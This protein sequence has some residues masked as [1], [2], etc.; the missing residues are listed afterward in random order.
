MIERAIQVIGR[1]RVLGFVLNGVEDG[2]EITQ[3]LS[4]VRSA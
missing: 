4:R 1:Q 2:S 3:E